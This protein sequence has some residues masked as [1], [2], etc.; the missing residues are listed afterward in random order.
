M[1]TSTGPA[2]SLDDAPLFSQK[3][4]GTYELN[5]GDDL[6][7]DTNEG[8]T[9]LVKHGSTAQFGVDSNLN[10]NEETGDL[11]SDEDVEVSLRLILCSC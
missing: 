9:E 10:V 8:D 2:I 4:L 6:K 5:N 7:D 1:H 11:V 3:H